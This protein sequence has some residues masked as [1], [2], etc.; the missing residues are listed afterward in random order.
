MT[1]PNTHV[2]RR[3]LVRSAAVLPLVP[4]PAPAQPAWPNGPIRLVIPFPPGGSVDQIARLVAPRLSADLGVPVVV[5]NRSGAAG[6][7]GTGAVAKAPPTATPGSSSS[8]PTR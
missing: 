3:T 6:S 4:T 5:E 1:R 7:V 2:R 8:T